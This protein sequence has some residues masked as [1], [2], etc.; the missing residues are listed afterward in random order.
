MGDGHISLILDVNN[1]AEMAELTSLD[2][3]DRAT[4]V[5]AARID[6]IQKSKEKQA[7]LTFKSSEEEH[8]AIPLAQVER[9]EKIKRNDIE[10]LG[11][12]RVM[13]YRRGSL[14]LLAIDDVAMVQPLADLD[15]LVVFVFN[16]GGQS[17]GL[18]GVGPVDTLEVAI[19]IDEVTL[20]QIGI[21]GSAILNGQTMMLVDILELV[22]ETHPQWNLEVNPVDVSQETVIERALAQ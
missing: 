21:M 12:R 17:I 10:Q 8:F 20:K 13:Q 6:S 18:L 2:H 16:V 19:D 3:T 11:N 22:Q 15:D 7:L 9:I 4:E 5:A 1:L 14:P